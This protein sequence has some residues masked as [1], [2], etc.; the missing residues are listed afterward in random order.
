MLSLPDFDPFSTVFNTVRK[1]LLLIPWCPLSKVWFLGQIYI[2]KKRVKKKETN[3]FSYLLFD[4]LPCPSIPHVGSVVLFFS[5]APR[6]MSHW[7]FYKFGFSVYGTEKV[8]FL[9]H[10]A[11]D[12]LS[13]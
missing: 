11:I 13:L 6:H 1:C 5:T 3:P 8:C 7:N 12:S 4:L 2:G 9:H 10:H